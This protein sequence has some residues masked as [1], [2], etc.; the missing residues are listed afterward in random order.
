MVG[1]VADDSCGMNFNFLFMLAG[2][3][4]MGIDRPAF[5][6]VVRLRILVLGLSV[7]RPVCERTPGAAACPPSP[8]ERR[9]PMI[10]A[11]WQCP[12]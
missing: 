11:V 5:V 3:L 1:Y 2:V 8:A 12:R 10:G 7:G 4:C 9:V 6:S